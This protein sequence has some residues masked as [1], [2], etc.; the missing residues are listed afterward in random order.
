M[1]LWLIWKS[2]FGD[3]LRLAT[4]RVFHNT[5]FPNRPLRITTLK[6]AYTFYWK[7]HAIKT[8]L[9]LKTWHLSGY[10]ISLISSSGIS[11]LLILETIFFNLFH[12]KS[13]KDRVQKDFVMPDRFSIPET[14]C[15]NLLNREW[16]S[17]NKTHKFICLITCNK[18]S[19][20]FLKFFT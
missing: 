8:G 1:H 16:N 10:V 2:V 15:L 7:C 13:A 6:N 20:N 11:S 3:Y 17:I 9:L 18:L 19:D 4:Q 5:V 14:S 12:L